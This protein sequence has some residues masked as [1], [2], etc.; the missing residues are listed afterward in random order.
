MGL[1]TFPEIESFNKLPRQVIVKAGSSTYDEQDGAR[2]R[3]IV[4]N[5]SGHAIRDIWVRAIV[6]DENSIPVVSTGVTP[7]PSLLHQG[8][9]ASFSVQ[10]ENYARKISNCHLT[11]DWKFDD[12][13]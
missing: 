11:V 5:N 13:E 4:I 2:L 12:R 10:V 8:G 7:E 3:G 6:L 9:I 1:E